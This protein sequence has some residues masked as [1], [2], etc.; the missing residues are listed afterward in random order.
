MVRSKSEHTISAG[1]ISPKNFLT[2]C[3]PYFPLKYL[4]RGLEKFL[5]HNNLMEKLE[6][7][8]MF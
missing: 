4:F 8:L 7:N 6:K 2:P 1:L 3:P 5:V